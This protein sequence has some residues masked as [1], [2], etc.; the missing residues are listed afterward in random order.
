MS[1]CFIPVSCGGC[2][3][4]PHIGENG[5]WYI[6][7]TDTGVQAQ[8][9]PGEPGPQGEKGD[10]GEPGP[11]GDNGLT[12]ER[13]STEKAAVG[14]WIDGKT[15]YRMALQTR[16]APADKERFDE[17][18]WDLSD[19]NLDNM[20]KL[21]GFM[22]IINTGFDNNKFLFSIP[23][24]NTGVNI[25]M[26]FFYSRAAK[27]IEAAGSIDSSYEIS[28]IFVIAEFTEN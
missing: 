28:K 1:G 7:D 6:G 20:V 12:L 22:E 3:S 15:I 9:Q 27:R 4:D 10:V 8:G 14:T 16:I 19:Y 21:Y 26:D 24:G 5:N 11:K 17:T 25:H 23:V 18:V 2:D 13:Y